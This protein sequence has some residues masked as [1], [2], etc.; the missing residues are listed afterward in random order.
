M[1]PDAIK[2]FLE[3]KYQEFN[4]PG[5]IESDPVSIPH[6]FTL[7]EDREIAG[8]L[9]A[10]IAWGQRKSILNNAQ[11]LMQLMEYSPYQFVID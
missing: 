6:L 4:S 9:A 5:F 10:T 3:Q 2:E 7:K 1:K 11:K 8:F